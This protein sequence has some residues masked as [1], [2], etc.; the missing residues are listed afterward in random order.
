[1]RKALGFLTLFGGA[2][3]PDGRT[4]RW[5]P[6][7]GAAIGA[8]VGLVWWGAGKG[9]SSPLVPAA[10]AVVVDLGLTGV[11]HLDGLADTADGLLPPLSAR[12]RL[13]VMDAPDLGAFGV[14]AAVVVLVAR[15]AAFSSIRPDIALVAGIWCAS[16]SVMVLGP[17][18][19]PYAR[20]EGGLA[21]A[22][23]GDGTAPLAVTGIV[24]VVAGGALAAWGA[25]IAGAAAVAGVVLAAAAVY[26]LANARL[27]GFTGDVLG[28]AGVFGETVALVLATAKW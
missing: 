17:V 7:V 23:L 24:G 26:A 18:L 13:E 9:W 11:L 8:L 6:A 14:A 10:L 25:G 12:R 27:G 28:A 21:S 4:M 15:F 3:V 5:F 16:R 20:A 1:M 22:F 19:V 2:S